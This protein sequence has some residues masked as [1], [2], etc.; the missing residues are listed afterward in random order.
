M[1]KKK[2]I[3]GYFGLNEQDPYE[4]TGIIFSENVHKGDNEITY[5]G[6]DLSDLLKEE[7]G[8]IPNCDHSREKKLKITI[9][10]IL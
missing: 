7:F 8:I 3:K 9:E 10:E 4:P 2:V 6:N 5:L 1:L